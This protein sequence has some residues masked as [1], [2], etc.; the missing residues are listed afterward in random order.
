MAL[1]SL[2]Y[3]RPQV[4]P[5]LLVVHGSPQG[6]PVQDELASRVLAACCSIG[7][8]RAVVQFAVQKAAPV[9]ARSSAVTAA[10]VE[11]LH[12]RVS[13]STAGRRLNAYNPAHQRHSGSM[14]GRAKHMRTEKADE[15]RI[16]LGWH[17]TRN[18]EEERESVMTF[19]AVFGFFMTGLF[20]IVPE[21]LIFFP[22]L[23]KAVFG[24]E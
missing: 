8:R 23:F 18:K 4:R 21:M 17:A 11:S 6:P 2:A 16:V 5:N 19:L 7:L 13:P 10:A 1:D 12:Q 24:V 14:P 3:R 22:A 9:C 15:K 20:F